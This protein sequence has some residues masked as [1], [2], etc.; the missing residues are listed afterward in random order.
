MAIR[1]ATI[2]P[3]TRRYGEPTKLHSRV[4][5][6]SNMP[7]SFSMKYGM[8]ADEAYN[9]LIESA[10]MKMNL[11]GDSS[12]LDPSQLEESL[13]SL[14]TFIEGHNREQQELISGSDFF[15]TQMAIAERQGATARTPAASA[16]GGGTMSTAP[17][18]EQT[19]AIG[20]PKG[21]GM[22]QRNKAKAGGG[23]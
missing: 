6:G 11:G 9:K 4:I 8:S 3:S 22:A 15:K 7:D 1:A 13:K 12:S 17:L 18:G 20:V 14:N 5:G 16:L 2:G 23:K 10:N 21:V 19:S